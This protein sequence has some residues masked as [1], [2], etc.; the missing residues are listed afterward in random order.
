LNDSEDTPRI[1]ALDMGAKR[2]GM[3][4]SDPTGVFAV[5]LQTV[6]YKELWHELHRLF[7]E[8]T[9]G[10]LVVGLPRHMNGTEGASAVKV[11]EFVATFQSRFPQPVALMDERLTTV[12]AHQTLKSQGISPSRNKGWVDQAAAKRILQDY[13]DSHRPSD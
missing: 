12:L 3:A 10:Q 6:A 7:T 8:Y 11:R 2:V 1:L 5:G 13:L 9:V 4:I